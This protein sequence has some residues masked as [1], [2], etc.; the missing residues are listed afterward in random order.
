MC[1]LCSAL[2]EIVRK[3]KTTG[4]LG[5]FN[6]EIKRRSHNLAEEKL[7]DISSRLE[8]SP[9]KSKK[10]RNFPNKRFHIH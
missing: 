3:F 1:V 7:G 6:K 5:V 4:S 2:H 10:K 9:R 8:Q